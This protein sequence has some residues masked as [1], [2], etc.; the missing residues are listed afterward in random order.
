MANTSPVKQSYPLYSVSG[1]F[2][3]KHNL[4]KTRVIFKQDK[5][6]ANKFSNQSKN[7]TTTPSNLHCEASSLN[8]TLSFRT[9]P[10]SHMSTR[11]TNS[12]NKIHLDSDKKLSHVPHQVISN[13][14]TMLQPSQTPSKI[15]KTISRSSQ[16][17]VSY[18]NKNS[19]VQDAFGT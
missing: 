15:N 1:V 18:S 10:Q 9:K 13:I 19:L 8:K 14:D 5:L 2:L 7:L 12:K 3:S 16:S 6:K 17:M 11:M 4:V